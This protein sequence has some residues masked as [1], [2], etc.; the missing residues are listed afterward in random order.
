RVDLDRVLVLVEPPRGAPLVLAVALLDRTPHLADGYARVGGPH[1][2]R[3]AAR[4]LLEA[5]RQE[6]LDHRV[7]E[8]DRRHVAPV[9]HDAAEALGEAP[10]VIDHHG[11]DLRTLGD[12]RD[13]RVDALRAD[14]PGH[15][16]A[17]D[18]D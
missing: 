12:P 18:A 15:V 2:L 17:V 9:R 4:P 8:H 6:D 14:G 11:A 10:L 7:R 3:A 1:L 16:L 13:R 5:R